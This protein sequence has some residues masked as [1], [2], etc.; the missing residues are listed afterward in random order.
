MANK[1]IDRLFLIIVALIC[2]GL[3]VLFL[4][5]MRPRFSEEWSKFIF[6]SISYLIVLIA[7]AFKAEQLKRLSKAK[8]LLFQAAFYFLTVGIAFSI[9]K[10]G[11]LPLPEGGLAYVLPMTALAVLSLVVLDYFRKM[12]KFF[13]RRR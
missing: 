3:I 4:A 1:L 13:D 5:F 7:I 2:S 10:L 6:T 9:F 8:I 11:L 12:S